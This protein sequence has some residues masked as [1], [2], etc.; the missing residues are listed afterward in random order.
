MNTQAVLSTVAIALV[1]VVTWLNPNTAPPDVGPS[2]EVVNIQDTAGPTDL[3]P[4]LNAAELSVGELKTAMASVSE[5][6]EQLATSVRSVSGRV[7]TLSGRISKLEEQQQLAATNSLRAPPVIDMDTDD[8]EADN[9]DT[10]LPTPTPAP[11]PQPSNGSRGS[12]VI[13]YYPATSSG[14]GP[15]WSQPTF[16]SNGNGSRGSTR[17]VAGHSS[18]GSSL[19]WTPSSS[20]TTSYTPATARWVEYPTTSHGR[21][22]LGNVSGA[23]TRTRTV[24]RSGGT[25]ATRPFPQL[26]Q[27]LRSGEGPLQR[28]GRRL[29]DRPRL[30]GAPAVRDHNS[31]VS[32]G[33]GRWS[34]GGQ[35]PGDVTWHLIN[36]H[37]VPA[38]QVRSMTTS[39]RYAL[40]DSIHEGSW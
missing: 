1:G 27:R 11:P 34:V 33:S 32:T 3:G 31:F 21:Q 5:S 25:A 30:F 28:L 10:V 20:W 14:W 7:D 6:V 8:G 37:G 26:G 17:L 2:Q 36:E 40:H 22:T 19:G 38:S 35:N 24:T 9:G 16:V 39:Q 12:T 29:R 23:V 13:G 18:R 15:S 4:R